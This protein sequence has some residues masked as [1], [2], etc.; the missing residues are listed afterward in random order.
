MGKTPITTS[1][2]VAEGD[3]IT[4]IE[5]IFGILFPMRI[6]PF[7]YS[8]TEHISGD[9]NG[10]Y[11]HYNTI[12]NGGFYMY[13]E[14]GEMFHVI[15]SNGFIGDVTGEVLGVSA[16]MYA[17]S[18]LSFSEDQQLSA[19]CSNHYYLLREYVYGMDQV[20]VVMAICD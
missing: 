18:H 1:T 15:C 11:W 2:L 10:G 20:D 12:N 3:R 6:E 13:P 7:I 14:S 19:L 8:I 5:D 16:C 17:Y 4:C 9:Y